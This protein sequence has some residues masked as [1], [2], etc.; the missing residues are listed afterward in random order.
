MYSACSKLF[1]SLSVLFF[2][3]VSFSWNFLCFLLYKSETAQSHFCHLSINCLFPHQTIKI[4]MRAAAC[5]QCVC[6]VDRSSFFVSWDCFDNQHQFLP[7]I[8][9]LCVFTHT[10]LFI[11]CF[12]SLFNF[13]NIHTHTLIYTLYSHLS[14]KKN[15]FFL[16]AY[17][18]Y[19]WC[20]SLS[21]LS[22]F[23]FFCLFFALSLRVQ[24]KLHIHTILLSLLFVQ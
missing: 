5:E 6:V 3:S 14:F 4:Y 8:I 11:D 1:L 21:F 12:C 16:A 7:S 18:L 15:F 17:L 9:F 22:L 23:L 10:D 19:C 2:F 24:P 20:W 13:W